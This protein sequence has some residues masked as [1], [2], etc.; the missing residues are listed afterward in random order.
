MPFTTPSVETLG[1]R[2]DKEFYL[3]AVATQARAAAS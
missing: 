3:V 2:L 1:A